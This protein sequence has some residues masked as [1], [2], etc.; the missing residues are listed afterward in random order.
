MMGKGGG[1]REN[2]R[3]KKRIDG[4]EKERDGCRGKRKGRKTGDSGGEWTVAD[5]F[6]GRLTTSQLK[7]DTHAHSCPCSATCFRACV[8]FNPGITQRGENFLSGRRVYI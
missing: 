4:K 1:K 5:N 8:T 2:G 6:W 3:E 7:D